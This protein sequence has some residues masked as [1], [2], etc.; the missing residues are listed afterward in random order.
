MLSYQVIQQEL[1][2][3]IKLVLTWSLSISMLGVIAILSF[4]SFADQREEIMSLMQALPPQLLKGLSIDAA[5]FTEIEGYVNGR[6]VNLY[7]ITGAIFA[8][9]VGINGVGKEMANGTL[10]FLLARP[11]MRF[12]I[13]FSKLISGI[14]II[15]LS[16]ILVGS[17]ALLT[18]AIGVKTADYSTNYFVVAFTAAFIFQLFFLCLGQFL[19]VALSEGRSLGVGVGYS[20]TAIM[21]NTIAFFPDIPEFVRYLT[22]YYYIDLPLAASEERIPTPEV[23]ILLVASLVLAVAGYFVFKKRNIHI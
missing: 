2:R 15:L 17:I 23:Y 5:S 10:G 6:F 1:R 16:T 19:G 20:F 13:Y 3:H 12:N 18:T 4:D 8:V 21:L 11:L 22:P 9:Y 7:L 14:I